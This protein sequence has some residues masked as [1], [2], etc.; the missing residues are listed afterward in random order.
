LRNNSVL[1]TGLEIEESE[2]DSLH[3]QRIG[4]ASKDSTGFV[5]TGRSI[6]RT[7]YYRAL[8]IKDTIK[9]NPS[10]LAKSILQLNS[11]SDLTAT[12]PSTTS[13]LLRWRDNSQIESNYEI[14]TSI[15]ID[16]GFD[17]VATTEQDCTVCLVN[18]LQPATRYYFRVRAAQGD[19]YSIYSNVTSEATSTPGPPPAP[20]ELRAIVGSETTVDLSWQ[21]NS[22]N[23]TAF[24]INESVDDAQHFRVLARRSSNM[25]SMHITG[26]TP[27][28]RHFYTVTAINSYGSA[29]SQDTAVA[30]TSEVRPLAPVN[31]EV[32]Q[33]SEGSDSIF[34]RWA[35]PSQNESGFEVEESLDDSLHFQK[36]AD[37]SSDSTNL[38]I[39]SRPL[40]HIAFYRIRAINRF[41]A[42]EYSNAT[43]LPLFAVNAPSEISAFGYSENEIRIEWIDNSSI[44]N[45]FE[46]EESV[47]GGGYQVIAS[48]PADSIR[49][50]VFN[51]P[52][53]QMLRYRV[54]AVKLSGLY[55]S[56]SDTS[57][58]F[59]AGEWSKSIPL[60]LIY[61]YCSGMIRTTG[62]DYIVVM[63]GNIVRLSENG[64]LIWKIDPDPATS[65]MPIIIETPNLNLIILYSI[66]Q[67]NYDHS[68]L[69]CLSQDGGE[70]WRRNIDHGALGIIFSD[71]GYALLRHSG[72]G[73][74]ILEKVDADN[75]LLWERNYDG[76]PV[77]ITVANDGGF[78]ILLRYGVDNVITN[79][80]MRTNSVGEELWRRELDCI[81]PIVPLDDGGYILL[82]SVG[83]L[84]KID[85]EGSIVWIGDG[86]FYSDDR[87]I[88]ILND[89]RICLA[90]GYGFSLFTATGSLLFT[91]SIRYG[92]TSSSNLSMIY[93]SDNY[94]MIGYCDSD[95]FH[96][97]RYAIRVLDH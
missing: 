22:D 36:I 57:F 44:E 89:G 68:M 48:L 52:E 41:G 61:P 63:N 3:F 6:G 11:P 4:I 94:L 67:Y 47:D 37:I 80:I 65:E 40:G 20:S 23:E 43:S 24:D 28:T 39:N 17:L 56:Y 78:M 31:L 13:L 33:T 88:V 93:I 55:S 90:G 38:V 5:V 15:R 26:R 50:H 10:N 96:F 60:D 82:N 76:Q 59:F 45:G 12:S 9:S 16:G 29:T 81:S 85:P 79:G 53:G 64:E 34:A 97:S 95:N 70:L 21:D 54:R 35:S 46:L 8:A 77:A 74:I 83:R 27:L 19:N 51:R 62:G 58:S 86:Q 1:A 73:N 66:I 84:I 18:D 69:L 71:F 42:S 14:E 7:C 32:H 92:W 91:R 30:N 49:Y 87:R 72:H 2:D 25:T 75:H